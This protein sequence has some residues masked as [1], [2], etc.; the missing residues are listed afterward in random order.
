MTEPFIVVVDD[1]ADLRDPVVEYLREEGLAAAGVR[2]GREL[3]ALMAQRRVDLVVLD[4]NMPEED[5][6]SIGRRLRSGGEL[7]LIYLTAKRDLIDRVAGLEL[8]ADD[9]L[10]KPF[11]PRELLA[12][13]RSVLRRAGSGASAGPAT[14]WPKTLRASWGGTTR[15]V[16]VDEIDWIEASKDY[17]LLHFGDRT[18]ILRA[19]I[20][21]L[22]QELDPAAFVRIHRSIIVQRN[23][24][25]GLNRRGERTT[26]NTA[27]GAALPVGPSYVALVERTQT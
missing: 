10:T 2:G 18:A 20:G 27:F 22:E 12:R 6:L 17:L 24:I 23:R 15:S 25:R 5:G 26:I 16:L 11:E 1:E 7:G 3:D 19:T 21:G 14:A 13:I 8:G 4:I 9:Y